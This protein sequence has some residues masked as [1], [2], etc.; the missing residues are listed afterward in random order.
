MKKLI[1]VATV[2]C[3]TASSVAN[4]KCRN[5]EDDG[6]PSSLSS[7]RGSSIEVQTKVGDP[8]STYRGSA[9][10]TGSITVRNPYNGDVLRGSV[11]SDGYG[12]VYD[13]RGNIHNIKP[14]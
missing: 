9:D 1:F 10:S 6:W 8:T 11:D 14:R 7:P 13:A 5:C 12:R 2:F 3:I 4:A